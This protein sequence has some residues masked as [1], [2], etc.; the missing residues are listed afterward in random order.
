MAL[1][2]HC[3]NEIK[4]SSGTDIT[5]NVRHTC[6]LKRQCESLKKSLSSTKESTIHIGD[7]IDDDDDDDDNSITITRA[8]FENLIHEKIEET[9]SCVSIGIICIHF[10]FAR[11]IH[12]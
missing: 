4:E 3:I 11:L 1:L 7:I 8:C 12:L 9:I 2:E 6:A 5:L 10:V